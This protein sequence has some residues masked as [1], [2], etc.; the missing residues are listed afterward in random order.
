MGAVPRHGVLVFQVG[1]T[2]EKKYV[3]ITMD[4]FLVWA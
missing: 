4:A 3:G 1:K 2:D